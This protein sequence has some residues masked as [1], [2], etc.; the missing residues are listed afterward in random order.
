MTEPPFESHFLF[1]CPQIIVESRHSMDLTA[2]IRNLSA[3][4]SP[5]I[6]FFAFTFK[7][8]VLVHFSGLFQSVVVIINGRTVF[9]TSLV[10]N[11]LPGFSVLVK[12]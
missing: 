5:F 4:G 10:R 6:P 12:T 8:A 9:Y 7:N 3:E 1:D 2:R 11:L